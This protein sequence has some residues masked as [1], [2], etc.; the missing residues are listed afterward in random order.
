MEQNNYQRALQKPIGFG[1]N[2]KSTADEVIKDIDRTGKIAIET[3]G[4]TS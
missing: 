3:G 1:F 2:A 4:L